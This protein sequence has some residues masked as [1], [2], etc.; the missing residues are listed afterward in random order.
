MDFTYRRF[1]FLGCLSLYF[2]QF[3][4]SHQTTWSTGFVN[5]A[6]YLLHFRSWCCLIT[7]EGHRGFMICEKRH[8]ISFGGHLPST[9][10]FQWRLL[11]WLIHVVVRILQ[12]IRLVTHIHFS[13]ELL[14]QYVIVFVDFI[15]IV[16]LGSANVICCFLS[17]F[18][19]FYVQLCRLTWNVATFL[20]LLFSVFIKNVGLFQPCLVRSA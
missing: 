1:I 9:N 16:I 6:K 3:L 11:L 17:L 14:D 5:L 13:L 8:W 15:L 2:H 19:W 4:K 12:Y 10:L 7:E 20:D 18:L